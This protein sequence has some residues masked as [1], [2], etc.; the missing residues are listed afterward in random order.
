LSKD[1]LYHGVAKPTPTG[2][3]RVSDSNAVDRAD[4][5]CPIIDI[6]Y[7]IDRPAFETYATLNEVRE[8]APILYNRSPTT[9]TGW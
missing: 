6:D 8:T 7:R 4:R 2:T 1:V 3:C 5:V 9:A